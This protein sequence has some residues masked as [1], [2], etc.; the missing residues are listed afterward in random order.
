MMFPYPELKERI[1]EYE[2]E[3]RDEE[4]VQYFE[5]H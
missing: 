4:A 2:E 3:I 5:A 1:P